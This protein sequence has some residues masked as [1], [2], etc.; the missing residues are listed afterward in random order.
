MQFDRQSPIRNIPADAASKKNMRI[1]RPPVFAIAVFAVTLLLF[2]ASFAYWQVYPGADVLTAAYG[3]EPEWSA[4]VYGGRIVA[5]R[6][7]V[8]SSFISWP[9]PPSWRNLGGFSYE[10]RRFA[11]GGA[12]G[13]RIMA[14]H[15]AIPLYPLPLAAGLLL[16]WRLHRRRSAP[17]PGQCQACGYDLRA[18]PEPGSTLLPRCPECGTTTRAP[19]ALP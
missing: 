15:L 1:T 9:A 7:H 3:G 19:A 14:E 16:A 6:H 5:S 8:V 11:T 2:A 10:R 17:K 18:T 4:A 12:V 13:G